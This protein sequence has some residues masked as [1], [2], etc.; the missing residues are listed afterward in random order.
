MIRPILTVG[1][2]SAGSPAS[3]VERRRRARSVSVASMSSSVRGEWV[4]RGLPSR[5]DQP[6]APGQWACWR[7][8]PESGLMGG[9]DRA[10]D[11]DPSTGGNPCAACGRI[12][13]ALLALALGFRGPAEHAEEIALPADSLYQLTTKTLEG[14][15]RRPQG[16]R[17]QGQPGGQ[18]GQPVWLHAPVRGPG[19]ALR[20]AQGPGLRRP[21]LPEQRLRRAGAGIAA[22][23]RQFCS[24]TYNVSFPMFEK[25]VTKRGTAQSPVFAN[26]HRQSGELPSWNFSKYLVG[27]DGKVVKYYPTRVTPEDTASGR[28]SRPRWPQVG[29][30]PVG[31]L[32]IPGRQGGGQRLSRGGRRLPGGVARPAP[33]E[34]RAVGGK[35]SSPPPSHVPNSRSPKSPSP[36]RMNFRSFS[37]R[38]MLAV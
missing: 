9:G 22:E 18:R 37:S 1:C 19:E 11:V 30:R 34:N 36:G 23:I 26:L 7:G 29:P 15:A 8:V 2:A 24:L 20:P 10:A 38:S 14:R 6:A 13:L 32:P 4:A 12:G 17:R 31:P 33:R 25:V 28:T 5:I 21:G 16:V 35:G 3:R 27:K